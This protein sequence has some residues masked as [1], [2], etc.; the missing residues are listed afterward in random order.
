MIVIGGSEAG[1]ARW[2]EHA[3]LVIEK[4]DCGHCMPYENDRPVWVA[5]GLK[6]S[7]REFWGAMRHYD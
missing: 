5:R 4:L 6:A 7:V 2:F 3:E 1:L